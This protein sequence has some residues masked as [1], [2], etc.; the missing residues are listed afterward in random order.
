MDR[1]MLAN[2]IGKRVFIA[3]MTGAFYHRATLDMLGDEALRAKL[4]DGRTLVVRY[5]EVREIVEE[6]E[7]E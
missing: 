7:T 4:E 2:L 1:E 6:S 5:D 3:T